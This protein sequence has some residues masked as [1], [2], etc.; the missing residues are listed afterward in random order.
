VEAFKVGR[1]DGLAALRPAG[2]SSSRATDAEITALIREIHECH[3]YVIDPHTACGFKDLPTDRPVVVLS[4][5]HPAKFPDAIRVATGRAVTHPSLEALKNKP[6]VK[7][8]LPATSS[9]V[10]DYLLRHGI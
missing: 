3:G 5:A 9:A 7:H 1:S 6:A 10:R 2:F 8:R 4:T